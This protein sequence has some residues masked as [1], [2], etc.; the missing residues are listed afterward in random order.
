MPMVC[1][2]ESARFS[3]VGLTIGNFDGVHG[4][5][6]AILAAGRRRADAAH[7]QLVAMIFEPHPSTI[8]TPDRVSQILTPLDEKTRWLQHYGADAV[9]VVRSRPDFFH[10]TAADF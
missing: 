1:D 8:L 9:V 3:G 6:Q 4:G 2:L 5:H 10:L 7:T